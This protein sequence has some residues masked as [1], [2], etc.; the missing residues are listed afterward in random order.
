MLKFA[1]TVTFITISY[2][3]CNTSLLPFDNKSIVTIVKLKHTNVMATKQLL[4]PDSKFMFL[5][6]PVLWET[7]SSGVLLLPNHGQSFRVLLIERRLK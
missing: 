5:R 2:L 7:D 4:F 3:M 6:V 1:F